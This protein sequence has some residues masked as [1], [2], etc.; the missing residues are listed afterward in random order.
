MTVR[1]AAVASFAELLQQ[2]GPSFSQSTRHGDSVD[3]VLNDGAFVV[4]R[5]LNRPLPILAAAS[6]MALISAAP[7]ISEGISLPSEDAIAES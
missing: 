6:A 4:P 2:S 7:A 1:E 5:V 3:P